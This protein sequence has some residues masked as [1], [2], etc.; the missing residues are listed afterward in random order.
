M[1]HKAFTLIELLVVIVIVGILATVSTATFNGALEKARIAKA[2][3]FARQMEDGLIAFTHGW[4]DFD[5]CSGGTVSGK[6]PS[7]MQVGTLIGASFS[8]DSPYRDGCSLE[9]DGSSYVS[10]PPV[11]ENQEMTALSFWFYNDAKPDLSNYGGEVF[12]QLGNASNWHHSIG[13]GDA[14]NYCNTETLAFLFTG[15][16]RLCSY[17]DIE[18]GWHHLAIMF[19]DNEYQTYL[20]GEKVYS[21][22]GSFAAGSKIEV[23][24]VKQLG[25]RSN[26]GQFYFNGKI[27]NLRIWYETLDFT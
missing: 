21:D 10:F 26:A 3:A 9:F 6:V 13:I 7:D 11:S 24:G 20:D 16:E 18:V 27:D 14:T 22:R 15:N 19:E 17:V 4:W 12:L 2:Q 5:E 8:T 1:K 23:P 25:R